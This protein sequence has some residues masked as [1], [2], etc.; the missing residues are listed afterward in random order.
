MAQKKSGNTNAG[1]ATVDSGTRGVAHVHNQADGG[2]MR[3]GAPRKAKRKQKR[4][5]RR[6]TT[7]GY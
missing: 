5:Q 4:T 1:V 2:S 3:L 7:R 6:G